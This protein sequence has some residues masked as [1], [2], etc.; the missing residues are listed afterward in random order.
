MYQYKPVHTGMY[1]SV[2][3]CTCLYWYVPVH[4]STNQYIQ[5]CTCLILRNS[6]NHYILLHD[7]YESVWTR[8]YMYVLVHTSIFRKFWFLSYCLIL[9]WIHGGTRRYMAVPESPVPLD[10]QV[11]GSTWRYKASY[12]HVLPSSCTCISRGTG[13][14]GT[15]MYLNIPISLPCT[16][17][18][19]H[20]SR[21]GQ[22][23]TRL[24]ERVPEGT[25]WH[26]PV[27]ICIFQLAW[28]WMYMCS[29]R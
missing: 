28:T 27:C 3:V 9:F 15:A 8:M 20:V 17:L 13:L 22:E 18:Y 23:D 12:L 29:T 2:L 26:E 16:A 5:V 10:M 21:R 19:R 14:S 11:Q 25:T 4:T 6:M 1:L 7:W 24:Y